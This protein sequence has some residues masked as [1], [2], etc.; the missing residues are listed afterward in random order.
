MKRIVLPLAVLLAL[1]VA[2]AA[3]WLVLDRKFGGAGET[4]T[5]RRVV[6]GFTKIE[7]D[8][9]ADVVLA[10]GPAEALVIEAPRRQLAHVRAEVRDGTL[11]IATDDTRRWWTGLLGRGPR[12][13]RITVTFR[14]L[15]T[16][17]ANGTVKIRADRLQADRMVITVTGAAALKIADLAVDE[18]VIAGAGAVKA[19]LAG[20]ATTQKVTISGA[21]DYRA[22]DLASEHAS[23]TVSGA[24]RVVVNAAKTLKVGL[25]GAGSVEY[26][27]D[28]EVT[29]QVSGAGRVKRRAWDD[30]GSLRIA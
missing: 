30:T 10:P 29:Q 16:L 17:R 2:A 5:E 28:P 7:V 19:D 22:A 24:G 3:A 9:Q 14:E 1:V 27:G 13:P 11:V 12:T 4:A 8:G 23:V 18:L 25:S 20:R 15:D 21:G 26:I 6:A